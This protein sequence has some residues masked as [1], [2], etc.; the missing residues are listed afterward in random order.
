MSTQ[1]HV[2]LTITG[3]H[4][5]A[6]ANTIE[7]GLLKVPGVEKVAVNFAMSS[8]AVDYTPKSVSR[9]QLIDEVSRLGY[10]ARERAANDV[11]NF[12]ID[13]SDARREFTTAALIT[14]PLVALHMATGADML[15]HSDSSFGSLWPMIVVALLATI[16]LVFSGREILRDAWAQTRNRR[17]N[18]NSLIALG[19]V[20]SYVFSAYNLLAVL[21]AAPPLSPY[22]YFET[23]AVIITFV[24]LGRFLEARARGK[25]KQAIAALL[26][27]RPQKAT[28]IINGVQIEID[29]AA[30][31]PGMEFLVKP[32]E[33]IPA[34][35]VILEGEASVDES[36]L[37]GESLPLDKSIGDKVI[38]GSLNGSR[39]FHMRVT[40]SG[41]ES[42]L[43]SVIRL[44]SDAQNA[45][46]PAQKLADRIAGIFTP[47]VLVI[48]LITGVAWY[49]LGGD[50]RA[51]MMF[52][53]PLSV[54]IIAC[55]CAL[56]L[57]TPTAI[58]AGVGRA[59]R[60]GIFFKGG[61]MLERVSVA[62]TV[63]FDKTGTLTTGK[64]EVVAVESIEGISVETVIAIAG[65]LESASEHPLAHG[66]LS[67]AHAR[68]ISIAPPRDVESLAGFGM[69]GHVD[70][71]AVLVGNEAIMKKAHVDVSVAKVWIESHGAHGRTII[72]VAQNKVMIGAIALAD[73]VKD[74]ARETAQRLMDDGYEVFIFTGDNRRAGQAIAAQIGVKNVESEL[75]PEQKS[76]EILA[77]SRTGRIVMMIGD[78]VNDAPALAAAD[79][80]VA[81]G[82]GTAVAKEAADVILVRPQLRD[83]LM[84]I[85]MAK[86]TMR[87]IRQNLFWAFAYN[88]VA[89]PVATGLFYPSFGVSLTPEIGAFAMAMSSVLVVS[90]SA[91]LLAPDRKT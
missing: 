44:V 51:R 7:E 85:D 74:D 77:L 27:L 89:I 10:G 20:V 53:M 79:V 33:A 73:T 15:N 47:I 78:G 9:E 55:P 37:T 72:L 24:L 90:N 86:L 61:D 75:R 45:K 4:C 62:D 1:S 34:D 50:D 17:A 16:V 69:R 23:S 70:G 5:A 87:V 26:Q 3:M 63:V 22:L 42:Y 8:A 49:F 11:L 43:S 81:I 58:L 54:L 83:I 65:S 2:N 21:V 18:M 56:G 25:T 48:A 41:E 52:A 30:A 71:V 19:A 35:G 46:A 40:A 88:V 84:A 38:G 76:E 59:A 36:M 14:G 32:G 91:R 80:G 6:C 31:Q 57:A 64:P 29:P 13:I 12:E 66:I 67:Y 82:A 68:N 60:R 39:P 28:A